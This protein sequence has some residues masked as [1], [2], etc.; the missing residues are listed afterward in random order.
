M[1]RSLRNGFFG[2]PADTVR[3]AGGV[4]AYHLTR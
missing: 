3:F 4:M 2:F 1:K